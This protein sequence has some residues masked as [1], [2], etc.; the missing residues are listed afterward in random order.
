MIKYRTLNDED[1]ALIKLV[2][3]SFNR[4]KPYNFYS[5]K[6]GSLEGES[7]RQ[8]LEEAGEEKFV[9][10]RMTYSLYIHFYLTAEAILYLIKHYIISR[11]QWDDVSES[12]LIV[13]ILNTKG[14]GE[15]IHKLA[16]QKEKNAI[17]RFLEWV[18]ARGGFD[19]MFDSDIAC[20]ELSYLIQL[21]G[22]DVQKS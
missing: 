7:L 4:K 13:E 10:R 2:E 1:I 15:A 14:I 8:Q 18:W 17:L 11:V 22:L 21:Y 20:R 12:L 6:K 3:N 9:Y 19:Q 16:N 5:F